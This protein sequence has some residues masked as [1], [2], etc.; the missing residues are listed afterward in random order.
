MAVSHES[1]K[2]TSAKLG[3]KCATG[4]RGVD[5]DCRRL[6]PRRSPA[7][8]LGA[9][10]KGDP[11]FALPVSQPA[12]H[13]PPRPR[14]PPTPRLGPMHKTP[15][16]HIPQPALPALAATPHREGWEGCKGRGRRRT[17]LRGAGNWGWSSG[18]QLRHRQPDRAGQEEASNRVPSGGCG[19]AQLRPH[20][21]GRNKQDTC[22]GGV[23]MG[24]SAPLRLCA[25]APLA[26]VWK[27]WICSRP[28]IPDV[29]SLLGCSTPFLYHL[30]LLHHGISTL[31][32]S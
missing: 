22:L 5:R 21:Q 24:F 31:Y 6:C 2:L 27:W 20:S 25:F 12:P 30:W 23:I 32:L 3:T 26:S 13:V 8:H 1:A 11:P 29:Y 9:Q 18:L 4:E 19:H 17:R 7:A 16:T 28:T 10:G 15:H 14:R